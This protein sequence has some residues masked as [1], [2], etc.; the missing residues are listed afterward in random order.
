MLTWLKNISVMVE[1]ELRRIRHDKTELYI[2][3]VQPV[4]WLIVYGPIMGATRAVPTGGIPYTDYIMP[5]V[6]IH[7][8]VFIAIFSGLQ[9]V[10]ERE[11]G[12]LKRL[13][14]TPS[15]RYSIVIGR[16]MASGVRAL[17]QVVII[18]PFALLI[19]VQF[20][21]DVLG[22]VGALVIIFFSSGGF[23]SISILVA[24]FMKSR[25]RFMG[26]GQAII[27]PLYFL[28]SA[29]YPIAV[30][31]VVLQQISIF[32][33]LSYIV[34]AVRSLLITGDFSSLLLDIG[35]LVLF[36]AVMFTLAT[37]SFKRIIE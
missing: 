19:G 32:N 25:E 14:V 20:R 3:A 11:S 7:S 26:I 37:L 27:F 30:M 6:L 24:A 23:A 22:F 36:D 17:F 21:I 12:I 13:L 34:D 9:V 8:T 29:L 31:P 10:W 18:V 15:G 2:R 35:V 33:P 1:L 4:L 5:G 28:S 16:A